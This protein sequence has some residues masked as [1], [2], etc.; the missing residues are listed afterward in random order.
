M[1]RYK[2]YKCWKSRELAVTDG[3]SQEYF[4]NLQHENKE[5]SEK[6]KTSINIE[7]VIKESKKLF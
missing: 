1:H 6:V 3:C 7:K 5:P 4:I 2:V